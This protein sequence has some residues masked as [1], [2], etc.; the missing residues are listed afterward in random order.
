MD[1][2]PTLRPQLSS[3]RRSWLG[4]RGEKSK[5]STQPVGLVEELGLPETLF[6]KLAAALDLMLF[7]P[8]KALG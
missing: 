6:R 3:S 5:T 7:S 4:G 1:A 2:N 8:K